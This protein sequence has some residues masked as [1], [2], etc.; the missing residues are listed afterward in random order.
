MIDKK[1]KPTKPNINIVV[2]VFDG[3]EEEKK[4][5]FFKRIK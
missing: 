1:K 5:R 2:K 3:E 4:P